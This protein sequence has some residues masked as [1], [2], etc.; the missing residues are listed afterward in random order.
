ML[1][2]GHHTELRHGVRFV[3]CCFPLLPPRFFCL[4][5]SCVEG[6][7]GVQCVWGGGGGGLGSLWFRIAGA[8]K[9]C[10]ENKMH[11]FYSYS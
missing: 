11:L 5:C 1:P 10:L 3:I 7:G 2:Q 4:L 9:D 6:L 8:E